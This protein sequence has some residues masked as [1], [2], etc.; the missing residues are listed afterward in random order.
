MSNI[1]LVR[2]SDSDEGSP[3]AIA[4]AEWANA[5]AALAGLD[6]TPYRLRE[7]NL[8]LCRPCCPQGSGMEAVANAGNNLTGNPRAQSC[9]IENV[10]CC[11]PRR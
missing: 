3:F 7:D 2:P 10:L 6:A 4:M 11:G 9:R 8:R 1:K 5:K